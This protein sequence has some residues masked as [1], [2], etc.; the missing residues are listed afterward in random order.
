MEVVSNAVTANKLATDNLFL[1][2]FSS[3]GNV[4]LLLSDYLVRT[5]GKLQPKGVF[6]V[7]SP[8]DLLNLYQVAKKNLQQASSE[9]T[10]QESNLIIESLDAAFGSPEIDLTKYVKL[11]P[12]VAQTKSIAN[13]SGLKDLKLRFYT[14]PD[15]KWWKDYANNDW[16]D[17]NAYSI[18]KLANQL[19]V[20][21]AKQVEYIATKNSGIRANGKRHP[22][23]WSIVDEKELIK[24]VLK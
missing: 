7:D 14:E 24:W 19:K 10:K 21:G 17:L 9:A 16:E 23:S 2:G 8:I 6:I 20:D 18:K 4:S 22:H 5:K 15:L 13:L 3:G 11:S 1:G 12:Y